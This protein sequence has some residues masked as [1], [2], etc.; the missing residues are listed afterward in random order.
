M[1][2]ASP[3]GVPAPHHHTSDQAEIQSV[4][5]LRQRVFLNSPVPKTSR[6]VLGVIPPIPTPVPETSILVL[7]PI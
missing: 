2:P 7:F 3:P 1:L 6:L 5:L 4:V